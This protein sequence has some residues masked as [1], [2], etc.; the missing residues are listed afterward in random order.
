MR[1]LAAQAFFI[2]TVVGI[3][4]LLSLAMTPNVP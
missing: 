1:L 2:A 4:F 3:A